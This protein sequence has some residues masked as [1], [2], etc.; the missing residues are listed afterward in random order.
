MVEKVSIYEEFHLKTDDPSSTPDSKVPING[1]NQ[2]P[3]QGRL[4]STK[5]SELPGGLRVDEMIYGVQ[6]AHLSCTDDSENRLKGSGANTVKALE[7]IVGA[8]DLRKPLSTLLKDH[9]NLNL[10]CWID[11]SGFR[12]GRAVDTQGFIA[13]N[14]D[15][16]VLSYRFSTTGLDW[17]TNLSMTSSEWEPDRDEIIGHAGVCSCVDGLFSKFCTSRGKPRVH[18]GFYNNFIYTIPMIRKHI[19]EPLL[20]SDATPKKVY[21]VGC[22]LGA[23]LATCAFCFVLQEML[24]SL[25]NPTFV[26]HKLINVTAGS[27]RVCDKLMQQTVMEGMAKLK[28]LDRAVICR[29][30]FNLDLVPHVPFRLGGF[31]HLDKLVYITNE[32]DVIINPQMTKYTQK[33]NEVKALFQSFMAKDK[34]DE[35]H[36]T[37]SKSETEKTPFEIECEKT[38]VPIKN[39]MPY[40][41][42]TRLKMLEAKVLAGEV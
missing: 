29:L 6:M 10:D 3:R 37:A 8:D 38:P 18:T 9:F 5:Y 2:K 28:P 33:F 12:M 14:E 23:A 35:E 25:E 21:I 40:W 19:L 34:M 39:H 42:L 1:T 4:Y 30:V 22:S 13:S 26:N 32:G 24:P 41:Y 15:T 7:E 27:P 16:I 31:Y 36:A 17:I 11:E 20:R